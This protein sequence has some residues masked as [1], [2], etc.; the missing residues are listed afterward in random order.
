MRQTDV[1]IVGAANGKMDRI[2][3]RTVVWIERR[4]DQTITGRRQI[5][6]QRDHGRRK[7]QRAFARDRRFCLGRGS[8]AGLGYLG[9]K[10]RD[11]CDAGE[12]SQK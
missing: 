2:L 5:R 7:Y 12:H 1:V 3:K 11:K 4:S 8:R 9:A 6:R 10:R